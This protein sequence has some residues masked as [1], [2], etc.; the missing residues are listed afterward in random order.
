[1]FRKEDIQ[2]YY[3]PNLTTLPTPP[4]LSPNPIFQGYLAILGI[5]NRINKDYIKTP[6][7]VYNKALTTY[8][9]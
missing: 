8:E 3:Y 2:P 5:D 7:R 6:K 4:K 9:T 1:M